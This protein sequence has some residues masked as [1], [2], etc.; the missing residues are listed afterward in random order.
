M[1]RKLQDPKG[2]MKFMCDLADQY[3]AK[4]T[5]ASLITA[6]N[7]LSTLYDQ[8]A[9]KSLLGRIGTIKSKLKEQGALDLLGENKSD[10][11]SKYTIIRSKI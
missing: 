1:F 10:E 8:H 6:Y 5:V 3:T 9:D 7:L 11:L 4:G 2:T